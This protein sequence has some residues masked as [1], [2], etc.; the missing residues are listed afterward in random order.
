MR[1]ANIFSRALP[2][3]F[4]FVSSVMG[5]NSTLSYYTT[6]DGATYAYTYTPAQ[7]SNATYLLLHGYPSSH[8]DWEAQITTLNAAG[9]GTLAPDMLGFGASDKPTD[10][11][12]YRAVRLG[13]HLIEL[14]DHE[15]VGNAIAVG[16]DW[17]AVVMS[18]LIIYHRERF[19]K[20]AFLDVGYQVPTGFVD[21]DA[22]NTL[23]LHQ[24]G[25]MPYGYWYFFDRYDASTVIGEHVSRRP[26]KRRC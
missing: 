26:S 21:I 25:Y 18:R 3:A 14:L 19:D 1:A 13:N 5:C 7:G 10:P 9:Y 17:G 22:F 11:E 4:L 8:K 16:H 20:I 6:T 24:W 23:G 2:L 15:G 12:A